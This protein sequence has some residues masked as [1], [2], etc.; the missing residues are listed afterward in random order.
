MLTVHL[1]SKI[2]PDDEGRSTDRLAILV[3]G[4]ETEKLLCVPKLASGTG[5]AIADAV[6]TAIQEWN[7]SDNVVAM[8]FDTTAVNTG[9]LSGACS[10]IEQRLGR[11]LLH[12]A[13]RHHILELVI[14]KAF[15]ECMGPSSGPEI[16][17]FIRF[18][19][20]WDFIDQANKLAFKDTDFPPSLKV[21]KEKLIA[22]WRL[23]LTQQQPRND[24]RE[25]LEL[26]IVILG[27]EV[28]NFRFRRPGALHRARWMARV[29]YSLKMLLVLPQSGLTL[30]EET[31][32]KRLA[33]FA[34]EIYISAWFLAPISSSAPVSDL[35]LLKDLATYHDHKLS[36]VCLRVFSR[37]LWYLSESLVGLSVFDSELPDE[38]KKE[39]AQAILEKN[40]P[41]DYPTRAVVPAT[42]SISSLKVSD[43]ASQASI[44]LFKV[45]RISHDFLTKDPSNWPEDDDYKAAAAIVRS[46]RVVNDTA[47]RGIALTQAFNYKVTESEDQ[48]QCLFQVVEKQR[49]SQPGTSKQ[50]L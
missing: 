10:I 32:L 36:T 45:L 50:Q 35:Q 16:G 4:F 8:G 24:Y 2:L 11:R 1:D 33:F 26:G 13:C 19:E 5:K 34:L 25:V 21:V 41:E 9:Y 42:I 39:I 29:I 49:H 18:R 3:T 31:A 17:I 44:A 47:E 14:E 48:R 27:G 7:V 30:R 46:I 38:I 28:S 12:L 37:H 15:N 6:T 20:R 23:Q 43:F 22:T 40:A